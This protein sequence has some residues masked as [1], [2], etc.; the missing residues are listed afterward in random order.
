MKQFIPK[1]NSVICADAYQILSQIPDNFFNCLITDPP[2]IL[3]QTLRFRD[4][5]KKEKNKL[6]F[7]QIKKQNI[8][9]A[10]LKKELK[11]M[12]K[13]N[14]TLLIK[15]GMR[16]CCDK[17]VAIYGYN[18]EETLFQYI[19]IA[20]KICKT[21][22]WKFE[23]LTVNKKDGTPFHMW[24]KKNEI[25]LVVYDPKIKK[26][27][28]DRNLKTFSQNHAVFRKGGHPFKK[29]IPESEW[30]LKM[31]A[32][33][34]GRILDPFCGGGT[35]LKLARIKGYQVFGIEQNEYWAHKTDHELGNKNTLYKKELN[36]LF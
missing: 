5:S 14:L 22:N 27:W 23:L 15:E 26:T 3:D 21:N 24:L 31:L 18:N 8:A 33:P 35:L 36:L 25:I 28:S 1:L 32:R 4:F 34:E 19:T 10:Y 20:F 29:G 11:T 16:I 30:L 12:Q 7:N 9:P 17:I 2:Y 6:N 13:I